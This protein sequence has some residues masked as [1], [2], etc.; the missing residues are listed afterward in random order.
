VIHHLDVTDERRLVL[1]DIDLT[2]VDYSGLGREW[3]AT[4]LANTLGLT[5]STLPAFP[6]R[7]ERAITLELLTS[8]GR[9][10][11][12][13][14]IQQMFAELVALARQR[15]DSLGS[16]GRA[17]PGAVDVLRAL[18]ERD[19]VVQSLVTGNLAEVADVKLAPFGMDSHLDLTI[20][21]YGS[22]SAQRSDLV[23]DAMR[24]A[25]EKHGEFKPSSVIVIGDT[26]HDVTAALHHGAVAVGVATGRHAEDELHAAGAHIVFRDLSDVNQVVSTILAARSH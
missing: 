17:L 6:G 15:R 3:Y 13:D 22:L 1:W 16:R 10:G 20:G 14:E 19:S 11:T 7:T 2:L 9:T 25:G 5:L 8:H 18:G 21:G 12:E 24:L 26:P 4:A 23:S